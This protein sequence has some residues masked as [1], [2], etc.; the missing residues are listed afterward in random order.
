LLLEINPYQ[1]TLEEATVSLV[2]II[3]ITLVLL[4]SI[5]FFWRFLF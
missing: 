4:L 1:E 3:V 5:L 2:K